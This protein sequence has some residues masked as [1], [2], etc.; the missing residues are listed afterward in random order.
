MIKR[1]Y[2]AGAMYGLQD[3]GQT[4]RHEVKA[5]LSPNWE[6]VIPTPYNWD[7]I[8]PEQL[9]KQDYELLSSS[10]LVMAQIRNPSWGTAM[11][12]A[13]AK[14][15]GITVMAFPKPLHVGRCSPWLQYHVS[16]WV[17]D[18]DQALK[19]LSEC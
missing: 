5:R 17:A 2:L 1:V 4:W 18:L 6:A 10:H 12:L 7:E 19:E 14:S 16:Y 13:F 3:Q 11:E 15:H 9:I 8:A